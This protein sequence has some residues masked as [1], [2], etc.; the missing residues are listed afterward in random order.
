MSLASS[1]PSS[2][3]PSPGGSAAAP[4]YSSEA[5]SSLP[6]P[7]LVGQPSTSTCSSSTGSSSA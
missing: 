2:P 5:P 1:P 7:S 3:L 4:P 6:A